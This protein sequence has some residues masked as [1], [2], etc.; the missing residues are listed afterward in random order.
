MADEI[1][2]HTLEEWEPMPPDKGPPLPKWMGIYWPWYKEEAANIRLS[3]LTIQPSE[4]N[5]RETVTISVTATNYSDASGSK[6]ITC[7]VNGTTS[8]QTVSLEGWQSKT[9]SFQATP[10]EEKTYSVSVNGLSGTFKAVAG[11]APPPTGANITLSNLVISPTEVNVGQK[12][13]ISITAT[14]QGNTAGSKVI[15]CTIT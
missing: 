14:N 5:I 9:V 8:E 15:T 2:G 4:C 6:K 11:A 12:V 1:L 7:S 10:T 3:N 13:T